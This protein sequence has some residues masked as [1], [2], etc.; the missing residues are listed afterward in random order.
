MMKMLIR[1]LVICVVLSVAST[2]FSITI[3]VIGFGDS[4][5]NAGD[6]PGILGERNDWAEVAEMEN[7]YSDS[8]ITGSIYSIYDPSPIDAGWGGVMWI[9]GA[10]GYV[11]TAFTNPSD[12]LFVQF[13]SDSNDGSADFYIDGIKEYS[14]NTHNGSWFAVVFSDLPYQVHTM[15]VVATDT[16]YPRDIAIDAMGS[17]ISPSPVPEPATV[18]LLGSGLFGLGAFRRRFRK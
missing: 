18:L 11:Q 3:D 16:Y 7:I 12:S 6:S 9:W 15:K 8:R 2:G 4:D 5:W 14:L 13:E 1:M 10:P 17:G